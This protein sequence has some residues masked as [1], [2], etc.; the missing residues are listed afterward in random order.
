M[1]DDLFNAGIK[2]WAQRVR[3][4]ELTFT[5]TV[6]TC[7]SQIDAD[8]SL[9]AWE[10]VVDANTAIDAASAMDSLLASGTDLGVT[11]GLPVAV[12]DLFRVDGYPV[13]NGSNA[14][15]DAL[16]GP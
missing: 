7:L 2:L 5:D 11:M 12:K 8:E 4:G 9:N 16:V 14:D 6:K 10:R 15:T 13:T 3:Q 1:S